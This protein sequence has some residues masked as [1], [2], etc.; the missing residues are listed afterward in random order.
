MAGDIIKVLEGFHHWVARRM[1]GLTEKRGAGGEWEHPPVVEAM[2]AVEINPIG[3][4]IIR[5]QATISEMVASRPM[6]E[7]CT[8]VERMPGMSRLVQWWDQDALN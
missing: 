2:E 6:Y 7:L 5:S 3:V 4:Y 8:E 1:T